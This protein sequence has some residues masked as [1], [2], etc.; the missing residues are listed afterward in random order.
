MR[1]PTEQLLDGNYYLWLLSAIDGATTN[2]E[3]VATPGL[4]TALIAN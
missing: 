4:G 2:R 1:T 3:T